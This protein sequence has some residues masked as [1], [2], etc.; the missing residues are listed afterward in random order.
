M[1]PQI[2]LDDETYNEILEQAKHRISLICPEWTDYN[3]HDPGITFLELL[4][5]L[6]E[7]QQYYLNH[8]E[9]SMKHYFLQ[10]LGAE[11]AGRLP[12][13][14][15]IY[16]NCSEQ[17]K[18]LSE[19][20]FYSGDMCLTLTEDAYINGAEAEK[21][22]SDDAT[23]NCQ[24]ISALSCMEWYPFG[25]KPEAGKTF[26]VV[27][28]KTVQNA[29]QLSL[30][31]DIFNNY[32]VK[33]NPIQEG[34]PKLAEF[35]AQAGT[36]RKLH[37]CRILTDETAAFTVSGRIVV[38]IP[39]NVSADRISFTL[40][41]CCYDVPPLLTG[42]YTDVFRVCQK[43]QTSYLIYTQTD[44]K[45]PSEKIFRKNYATENLEMQFLYN[46]D[47]GYII[48]KPENVSYENDFIRVKVNKQMEDKTVLAV[49]SEKPD[50]YLLH[51]GKG[52]GFPYQE[53]DI[54]CTDITAESFSL[55]INDEYDKKWYLW[56]KTDDL[57]KASHLDRVYFFDETAGKI[58][59]GDGIHGRVPDGELWITSMSHTLAEKGCIKSGE[60]TSSPVW[61]NISDI[62]YYE[63]L[64]GGA[65]P[66]TPEECRNRY[67]KARRIPT[68]AVTCRDYETLVRT[69]PGLMI[70]NCRITA[71]AYKSNS[72]HIAVEPYTGEEKT[73]EN[74][75]YR[76]ILQRHLEKARLIGTQLQIFFPKY[77]DIEIYVVLM[78]DSYS[79]KSEEDIRRHIEELFADEYHSFGKQI[80]YSS[81]YAEI[82]R[83]PQ[84]VQI[85]ELVVKCSQ[86]GVRTNRS[87]DII[88]PENGLPYLKTLELKC[89]AM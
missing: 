64:T 83:M 13:Y 5:W 17:K 63:D 75:I 36:E 8:R 25:K 74:R 45:K 53:F 61:D 28:S 85:Q 48:F 30:Y 58:S 57:L 73:A 88:L 82:D 1:L 77:A 60:I 33:R 41:Q 38:E 78:V 35:T 26:T 43:R 34:Y 72:V 50:Q 66:E 55:F 89:S 47:T 32:P 27:L 69:A 3:E 19:T 24:E 71:G 59:F 54:N 40:E 37:K 52:T 2:K 49:V 65:S 21:M 81:I 87:G 56:E 68:R 29:G 62:G 4:S 84:V 12:S 39:E 51:P 16:F 67:Q 18:I 70:R 22:I 31:L 80:L 7:A 76:E 11:C 9:N 42:I 44:P 14:G 46:D 79:S 20:P 10:L 15:R 6:K 86:D 23:I